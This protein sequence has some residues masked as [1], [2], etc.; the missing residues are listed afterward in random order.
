MTEPWA[1]RRDKTGL[2]VLRTPTIAW[3]FSLG[4]A[5]LAGCGVAGGGVR[6]GAAE[7]PPS[8]EPPSPSRASTPEIGVLTLLSDALSSLALDEA[9]H[10]SLTTLTDEIKR[11]HRGALNNRTMLAVD[12]AASVE[13]GTVDEVRLLADADALGHARVEVGAGDGKALG[14]L[15]ALLRPDQRAKLS[16]NLAAKAEALRLD[17]FQSRYGLWR[18]D[19][20]TTPDQDARIEP[21]LKADTASAESARAEREA[22]QKR[23]RT[24]AV[25]FKEPAFAA[26]QLLDPDPV[27]TTVAR[28][29]RLVAFLKLVVP[30][31]T[32]E[33]RSRA[34]SFIRAEAGVSVR[35]KPGEAD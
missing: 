34:A 1:S 3:L 20:R 9:Q 13:A 8:F 33:Q 5:S 17:D 23:V 2:V 14:D 6:F 16:A 21:R 26:T 7:P 25:A 28:I 10:R 27:A 31:L 15:H 18:A 30:E 35:S 32:D 24:T 11:R 12:T 4:L 22:W 19:L 29:R